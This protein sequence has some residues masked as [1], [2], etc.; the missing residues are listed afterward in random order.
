MSGSHYL[1]FDLKC[2]C[3]V[4]DRHFNST[5]LLSMHKRIEHKVN[6]G[7]KCEHCD[8]EFTNDRTFKKHLHDAHCSG[9]TTRRIYY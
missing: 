8:K 2:V 4:C 9:V 7:H 1:Y 5:K 3:D 6:G